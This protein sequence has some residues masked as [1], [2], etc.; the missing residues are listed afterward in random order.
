MCGMGVAVSCT[1]GAL[2]GS[3]T[4][5]A[6]CYG[7]WCRSRGREA[8]SSDDDEHFQK[9]EGQRL[10]RDT[11]ASAIFTALCTAWAR[12]QWA[13]QRAPAHAACGV[14]RLLPKPTPAQ[15]VHNSHWTCLPAWIAC[16]PACLSCSQAEPDHSD[17]RWH[18]GAARVCQAARPPGG[19][20]QQ[21]CVRCG[22]A[23]CLVVRGR[24][25]AMLGSKQ[26]CPGA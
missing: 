15:C 8:E 13:A 12:C 19:R 5:F 18:C 6:W 17:G 10:E 3:L 14:H 25:P 2:R 20:Q 9:K 4:C 23:G 11:G 26:A 1:R 21:R 22:Q 24:L 16:L 7:C